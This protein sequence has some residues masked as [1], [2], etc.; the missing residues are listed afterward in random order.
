MVGTEAGTHGETI[1]KPARSAQSIAAI[2][3]NYYRA[4]KTNHGVKRHGW[5]KP[6]DGFVK[7]N[8]DASFSIADEVGTPGAVL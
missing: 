1:Q 8:V 2:A 3:T 4:M 7:L 6:Q 5:E